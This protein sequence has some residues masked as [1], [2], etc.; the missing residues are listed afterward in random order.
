MKT[1]II[2]FSLFIFGSAQSYAQKR[3]EH[4]ITKPYAD[5][6]LD[7]GEIVNIKT[8]PQH[9]GKVIGTIGADYIATE[10]NVLPTR[11]INKISGLTMGVNSF[12]GQEPIFKGFTGGTAYFIDGVRVRSGLGLAGFTY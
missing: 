9:I 10:I 6:K 11:S 1:A 4:D 5:I 7:N 8:A 12:G 3:G 2:L